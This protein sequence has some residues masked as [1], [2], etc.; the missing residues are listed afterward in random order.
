ML[1]VHAV[2]QEVLS[3]PVSSAAQTT[4]LVFENSEFESEDRPRH[5]TLQNVQSEDRPSLEHGITLFV[6]VGKQKRLYYDERKKWKN[7]FH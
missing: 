5:L 6:I 3:S 1:L 7:P 2:C 4:I